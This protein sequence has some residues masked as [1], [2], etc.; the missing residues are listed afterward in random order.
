LRKKTI[1]ALIIITLVTTLFLSVYAS[2]VNPNSYT[3]IV[4]TYDNGDVEV[5]DAKPGFFSFLDPNRD[6][7]KMADSDALRIIDYSLNRE[8]SSVTVN[9]YVVPTFLGTVNSYSISSTLEGRLYDAGSNAYLARL[10]GPSS[11]PFS[12]GSISSGQA[13]RVMSSTISASSLQGLYSNWVNGKQYYYVV[14]CPTDITVTLTFSNGNSESL[15]T[16]PTRMAY[17]F[18]WYAAPPMPP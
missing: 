4:L 1:A 3:E 7:L 6:S 13:I 14:W 2:S 11:V 10:W 9:F 12:G 8:I 15:S 5:F 18:T 16:M 17:R